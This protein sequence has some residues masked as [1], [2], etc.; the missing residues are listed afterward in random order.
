[1]HLLFCNLTFNDILANSIMLPRLLSDILVPP[2]ERIISYECV[3]I[4]LVTVLL[5]LTIRLN[6]CR[7]MITSPYCDYAS[8]FKLSYGAFSLTMDCHLLWCS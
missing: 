8:L 3:V 4:L 7:T 5:G 2:S 1:M 6:R